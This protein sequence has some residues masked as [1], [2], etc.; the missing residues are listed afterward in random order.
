[1]LRVHS[2]AGESEAMPVGIFF[3]SEEE[4]READREALRLVR[5]RVLDVGA[6]VGC[7]TLILQKEG[8][9]VAAIE[10]IPEAV[11]IMRELGVEEVREGR[12]EEMEPSRSFDTLLLLMNGSAL[13]GTLAGFP[14]L[15]RVLSGLLAHGGQVL[16]ESTDMRPPE[17][18]C[19]GK[20]GQG[21]SPSWDEGEYPGELQYQMEFQGKKGAPFPQLFLD[22]EAL[23]TLATLAGWLVEIV[24]SGPEGAYLARLI[25][26]GTDA[27]PWVERPSGQESWG[28]PA[29]PT[30][31]GLL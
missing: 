27:W 13:A 19:G 23:G 18:S 7:M 1:V 16:M 6:G 25:R 4:L 15:L 8:F 3:R 2:D 11:E 17:P 22:P 5:G 26:G 9:E 28:S 10:A 14:L 29:H 21:T 12:L 30:R 31:A 20:A 24:W